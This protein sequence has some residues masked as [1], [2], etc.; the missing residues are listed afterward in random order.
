[1]LGGDRNRSIIWI[2]KTA[3]AQKAKYYTSNKPC[4]RGHT[5]PRLL[6]GNKCLECEKERNK[7]RPPKIDPTKRYGRAIKHKYG[8]TIEQYNA[9]LLAQNNCCRICIRPFT[10][11]GSNNDAPVIDHCHTTNKIRGLICHRCNKG[12]GAFEDNV[13]ILYNAISYLQS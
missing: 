1:M 13:Q 2:E 5:S 6:S 11:R 9:L 8:L 3:I 10:E 4:L 7:T 12:L